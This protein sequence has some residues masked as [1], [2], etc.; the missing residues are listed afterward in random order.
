MPR[1]ASFASD[2]KNLSQEH[3]MQPTLSTTVNSIKKTSTRIRRLSFN[4]NNS[5]ESQSL[6]QQQLRNASSFKEESSTQLF[7]VTR[8]QISYRPKSSIEA[9]RGKKR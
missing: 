6:Y 2:S 5:Q 8:K 4:N 3:L 1:D 9:E 7:S